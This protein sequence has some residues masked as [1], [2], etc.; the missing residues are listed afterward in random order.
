MQNTLFGFEKLHVYQVA[1]TALEKTIEHRRCWAGLP[2]ELAPQL[3]TAMQSIVNNIV[4]G[5]G[6]WT[7]RDQKHFYRI[8][9]AS[10]YESAGCIYSAVNRW[11]RCSMAGPCPGIQRR[12]ALAISQLW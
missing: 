2:G 9:R 3:Q 5:A 4:E 7:P 11:L 8:A 10:T 12:M 6:R 1:M